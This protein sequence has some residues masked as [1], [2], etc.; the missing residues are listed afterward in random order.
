MN[1]VR[2]PIALSNDIA[3]KE[4]I[5]MLNISMGRGACS[6]LYKRAFGTGTRRT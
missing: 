4:W 5:V 3:S 2:V 1:N 6:V